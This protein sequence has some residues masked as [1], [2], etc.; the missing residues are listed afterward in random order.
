M[1]YILNIGQY[2]IELVEYWEG[3][4]M[5][6]GKDK[7]GAVYQF[8]KDQLKNELRRQGESKQ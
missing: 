4:T 6:R 1:K 3:K 8:R 5:C 7:S 2:Q